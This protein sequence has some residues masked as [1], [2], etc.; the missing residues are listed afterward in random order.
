M[1]IKKQNSVYENVLKLSP[2]SDTMFNL[3]QCL[4]QNSKFD[5]AAD[6][7]NSLLEQDPQ[8]KCCH[9]KYCQDK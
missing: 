6:I 2:E 5:Q 9:I 4:E 8:N 7:Y 1:I 3:A